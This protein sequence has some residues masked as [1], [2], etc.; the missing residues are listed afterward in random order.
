MPA[1]QDGSSPAS[2]PGL[3]RLYLVRHGEA[4]PVARDG[5]GSDPWLAPLTPLGRTQV[6]ALS[7]SLENC[8]LDFLV[9]SA[10]P[11]ALETADILARRVGLRPVVEEGL[12]ELQPGRVLAGSHADV[13]MAIRQAYREAGLPGA[14]FLDGES[15]AA[16]GERIERALT[17]IL[18]QPGW[19]RAAV[20]T[21]EPALRYVLARCHGLGLAGLAAF[22]VAT[23]S[24]S[25]L[26]CAPDL[27]TIDAATLRLAN[28]TAEDALRFT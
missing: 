9:T 16:F 28:G 14:K 1:H 2:G 24:L 4:M 6:A 22:E 15:F 27:V 8:R 12:N 7:A 11:R 17:R 23:G 25:V 10:V 19:T 20:V 18:T 5:P 13:K 3:R 21:H 26:D